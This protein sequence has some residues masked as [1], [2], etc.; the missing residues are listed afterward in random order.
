MCFHQTNGNFI[1]SPYFVF[2][3]HRER[4]RKIKAILQF[5]R[6]SVPKK[7]Q[8]IWFFSSIVVVVVILFMRLFSAQFVVQCRGH[9][10]GTKSLENQQKWRERKKIKTKTKR[11]MRLNTYTLA[12]M[13][14]VEWKLVDIFETDIA[15]FLCIVDTS[16]A[17]WHQTHSRLYTGAYSVVMFAF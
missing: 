14:N 7:I 13:R 15:L 17:I 6:L 2:Y 5:C 3:M 1:Y 12:S 9:W 11:K 8:W 4:D 16:T 10:K